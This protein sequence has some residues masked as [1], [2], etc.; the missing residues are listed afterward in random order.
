VRLTRGVKLAGGGLAAAALGV[1]AGS[2][3]VGISTVRA[4]ESSV[5][6]AG[7]ER[8]GPTAPDPI[9]GPAWALRVYASTSGGSCVQVGRISRGR[10][11]Q[12]DEAGAFRALPLE[13]SGACG[14]LAAEPVIVAIDAYPAR[15]ERDARTVLYGRASADVI[16]V[17]VHRRAGSL[18][19]RPAIGATGGFLLPLAGTIAPSE[20]PLTITLADGR[21]RIYDWSGVRHNVAPADS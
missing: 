10:F 3:V 11:G 6:V 18:P 20:L 21:M 15:V 12:I 2:A 13:P 9:A 4:P 8:I 1:S 16:G 17:L 5:P 14:D 19:A 7:S